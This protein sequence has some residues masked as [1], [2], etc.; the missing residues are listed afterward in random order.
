MK[1]VSSP[2]D[3]M[4][5]CGRAG[6]SFNGQVG[7][8]RQWMAVGENNHVFVFHEADTFE[9]VTPI[10]QRAQRQFHPTAIELVEDVQISARSHLKDH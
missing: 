8:S 5:M 6:E 3:V 2:L 4:V 7:L 1:C 9:P 10:G